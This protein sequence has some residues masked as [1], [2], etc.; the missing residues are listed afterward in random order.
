MLL[1]ATFLAWGLSQSGPIDIMG[2]PYSAETRRQYEAY[3]YCFAGGAYDRRS[4]TGSPEA[5]MRAAKAACRTEYDRFVASVVRDSEGR[6][7]AVTAA[8]EA[9]AL[10]D[11][12]DARAVVGPPPPAQL[13]Q[14]PVVRLVGTWR[15]GRGPLAVRMTVRFED[16]GSLVGILNPPQQFT[17]NGLKDWRIVSNGTREA[18]LHATFENGRVVRFE[19]I[20]SFPGEVNFINP[21]DPAIQ[22]FD[23]AMEDDELLI[24]VVSPD[25]GAQLRFHRDSGTAPGTTQD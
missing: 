24:R 1:A 7:D 13:A 16:D 17:A 21:A 5:N 18:V 6:A 19:R 25:T 2:G 23:L 14:L 4:D 11:E 10:L 9:R 3:I 22:R 15:L 20:P 8:A 12:M